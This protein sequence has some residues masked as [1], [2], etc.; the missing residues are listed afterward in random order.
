MPSGCFRRAFACG[1][2]LFP[3]ICSAAPAATN[4]A[5]IEFFESKIRPLLVDNCYKCHSHQ[6]EKVRG[7]FMLDTRDGLLQGRRHRPGHRSRP[8]GKKPAHQGGQLHR[9]RFANAA[10]GPEA[11]G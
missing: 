1:L 11:G 4:A 7:G 2:T 3:L 10:E 8:S 6:S 5:G 9:Q